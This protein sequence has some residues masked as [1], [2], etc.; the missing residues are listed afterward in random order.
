MSNYNLRESYLN[1]TRCIKEKRYEDSDA[2]SCTSQLTDDLTNLLSLHDI[3]ES[4]SSN[5]L[6]NKLENKIPPEPPLFQSSLADSFQFPVPESKKLEYDQYET[7]QE[8]RPRK[9]K[10]KKPSD[11]FDMDEFLISLEG[12]KPNKR[13]SSTDHLD[14]DPRKSKSKEPEMKKKVRT[15]KTKA[16][17]LLD[18]SLGANENSDVIKEIEIL[19]SSKK[20]EKS[21]PEKSEESKNNL[22]L[23]FANPSNYFYKKMG[24]ERHYYISQI[25]N[26]SAG[27]FLQKPDWQVSKDNFD[28]KKI[29]EEIFKKGKRILALLSD[30]KITMQHLNSCSI[31]ELLDMASTNK[32]ELPKELDTQIEGVERE[33]DDFIGKNVYGKKQH[34]YKI[35]NAEEL[36]R[37]VMIP[38]NYN[39]KDHMSRIFLRICLRTLFEQFFS[40]QE[41]YDTLVDKIIDH[42]QEEIDKKRK[43]TFEKLPELK[44]IFYKTNRKEFSQKFLD[45]PQNLRTLKAN[46]DYKLPEEDIKKLFV[47]FWK[48]IS[49]LQENEKGSNQHTETPKCLFFS[50]LKQGKE[51]KNGDLWMMLPF[52]DEDSMKQTQE[53][54][55]NKEVSLMKAVIKAS[56]EELLEKPVIKIWDQ[57]GK[58]MGVMDNNKNDKEVIDTSDNDVGNLTKKIT[59]MGFPLEESGS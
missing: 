41:L 58:L 28:I 20:P 1:L 46:F 10:R 25:A 40:D 38:K 34:S 45:P 47:D 2:D 5:T 19:D 18:D 24:N 32:G 29:K 26:G 56:P 42:V 30:N 50:H 31:Q 57:N 53:I 43:D 44:K 13:H 15:E 35:P 27:I 12:T 11:A 17:N 48:M 36:Q 23:L 55:K 16:S 7:N 6:T 14:L 3:T 54:L 22:N 4:Q 39:V 9:P 37:L 49:R 21:S 8:K 51:L 33:F 59:L 52:K